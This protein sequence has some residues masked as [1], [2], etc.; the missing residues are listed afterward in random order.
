MVYMYVCV[1]GRSDRRILWAPRLYCPDGSTAAEAAATSTMAHSTSRNYK[2]IQNKSLFSVRHLS[3]LSLRVVVVA[4]AV[5]TIFASSLHEATVQKCNKCVSECVIIQNT[6]CADTFLWFCVFFFLVCAR[7]WSTRRG[8]Q[9]K[10]LKLKWAKAGVLVFSANQF[11]SLLHHA[12]PN[13]PP[14]YNTT[15]PDPP[16]LQPTTL[17]GNI[18]YINLFK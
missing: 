4:A 5:A 12:A 18:N 1:R 6:A 11:S 13:S 16:P 10:K 7:A 3:S 2:I 15:T 14:Y 17:S 8:E 9:Q